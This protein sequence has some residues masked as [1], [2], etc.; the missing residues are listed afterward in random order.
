VRIAVVGG[1]GTVGRL[2]VQEA[3]ET[4]ATAVAL[5][6]STG[7][8]LVTGHGL[9]AALDGCDAVVDVGNVTTLSRRRSVAFFTAATGH[10]VQA[11]A[12]TGVGHLVVLS[13]V[14]V[15]EVDSG[16]YA[17]KRRQEE[18]AL[19]G[20][21]PATV[22]RATQFHEFAAQMLG[23]SIGPLVPVPQMHCR[24]VSAREVARHL[25]SLAR[26]PAIGHAPELAGP[27]EAEMTDLV[28]RLAR[29]RGE[30]RLVVPL[31]LPGAAGRAMAADGLLPHEDGPR[32]S[33][34]FEQWLRSPGARA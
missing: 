33:V 1:T 18:V 27:E 15:D 28:R 3:Q 4:G 5:A 29:A 21:V 26:G 9:R 11:C 22:L 19:A 14:G 25:V 8:D 17:G 24:P 34:T 20:S 32:G 10:L 6:R 7:V 30:R 13:I 31:R 2:V 23:T 12:D 16:Y